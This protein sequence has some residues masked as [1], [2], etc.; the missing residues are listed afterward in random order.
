MASAL[1]HRVV[2]QGSADSPGNKNELWKSKGIIIMRLPLILS[3]CPVSYRFS[4]PI[5]RH[6]N[7]HNKEEPTRPHQEQQKDKND[8]QNN[9]ERTQQQPRAGEDTSQQHGQQEPDPKANH[10]PV[11]VLPSVHALQIPTAFIVHH[12]DAQYQ[13]REYE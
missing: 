5:I 13:R 4:S 3:Q 9:R 1:I 6:R 8:G 12:G 10:L 7:P 11:R 2:S